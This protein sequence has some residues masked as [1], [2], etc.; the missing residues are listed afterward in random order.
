[1]PNPIKAIKGGVQG[2]KNVNM[3][4]KINNKAVK[5]GTATAPMGAP[6]PAKKSVGPVKTV[7]AFVAGAQNPGKAKSTGQVLKAFGGKK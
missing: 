3:A 7:Q 2:V 1:M 5:D 4:T 6:A